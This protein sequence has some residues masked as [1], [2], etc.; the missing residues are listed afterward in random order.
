MRY[1]LIRC[2]NLNWQTEDDHG[3]FVNFEDKI[4]IYSDKTY[5]D[6][7]KPE[8][9]HKLIYA[10][11][12]ADIEK[13]N[14]WC[15]KN[16]LKI[17][18]RNPHA[19]V[20]WKVG[21]GVKDENDERYAGT[22][23]ARVGNVVCVRWCEGVSTW[24]DINDLSVLYHKCLI[25]TNYEQELLE[26]QEEKEQL[27]F[28]KGD[29]VLVRDSLDTKWKAADFAKL[30]QGNEYP[31]L[32]ADFDATYEVVWRYCIPYNEKTWMLLGTTNNYMEESAE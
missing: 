12:K 14:T 13:A 30:L 18:P 9:I 2:H 19:Y 32:T 29:R 15:E 5:Y 10:C 8:R 31:Y 6:P 17:V 3:F 26:Q 20:D 23:I 16:K 27:K 21:D 7:H 22:V 28:S 11:N 25:L 4:A 1:D 24:Y